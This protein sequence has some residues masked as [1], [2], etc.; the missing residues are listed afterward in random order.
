MARRVAIL[1]GTGKMGKW[2]AKFFQGRGF[3]V[4]IS[5]RSPGKA[6]SVAKEIGVE[7]A[8]SMFDAAHSADIVLV[9]TPI[10]V[11]AR[12]IREVSGGLKAEAIIFDIA[13]IKGEIIRAL[14]EAEALGARTLSL[15]PLFGP[16]A[17]SIDGKRLLIIPVGKDSDLIREV[18]GI[19]EGASIHIVESWEYHDRMMALTLSLPHFLN[20]TFGKILS[21]TDINEL[22]KFGGTT[23][24]LQLL[25]AE[26][27]LSEDP[28]LYYEIQSQNKAFTKILDDFTEIVREEVSTI[29]NEDKERFVKDFENAADSLSKDPGFVNAYERFYRALNAVQQ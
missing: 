6:A 5:S 20:I 17:K 13:S 12:V 21:K 3:R 23:F 10:A 22:K 15:H 11:T 24:T 16:G 9:A 19:F 8:K 18:S 25:V 26:T 27:V 7:H 29:T 4:V 28:D 2:F 14:E 1:G